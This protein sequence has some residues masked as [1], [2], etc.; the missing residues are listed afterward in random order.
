M[1]LGKQAEHCGSKLLRQFRLRLP[2]GGQAECIG[3]TVVVEHGGKHW[4]GQ[5]PDRASEPGHENLEGAGHQ[6]GSGGGVGDGVVFVAVEE[7]LCVLECSGDAGDVHA[8]AELL[9]ETG[10]CGFLCLG[11]RPQDV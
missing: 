11:W 6:L 8:G 4:P 1:P 3:E 2:M 9:V 10:C 5:R 7:V